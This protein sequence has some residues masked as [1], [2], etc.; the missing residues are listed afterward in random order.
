MNCQEVISDCYKI[1]E[2]DVSAVKNISNY[3][4]NSKKTSKLLKGLVLAKC[5]YFSHTVCILEF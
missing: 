1:I 5:P 3:K 4:N 2:N